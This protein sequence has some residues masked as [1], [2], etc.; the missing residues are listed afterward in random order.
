MIR[1]VIRRGGRRQMPNL[2]SLISR[3]LSIPNTY[4]QRIIER[5]PSTISMLIL[6]TRLALFPFLFAALSVVAQD[7]STI[8]KAQDLAK[9]ADKIAQNGSLHFTQ[10]E[11]MFEEAIAMAPNDAEVNMG[12][13]LCQLNGPFRSKALP[14]FQKARVSD[15]SFRHLAFLTGYALQLDAQWD[16]AMAMYQEHKKQNPYLDDPEVMYN[17]VD[18]RI[19]ECQNGVAAMAQ[20]TK[21][22]VKNMGP[23]INSPYADYGPVVAADGAALYYTSRRPMGAGAK[24]NKATKEYF[25]DIHTASKNGTE[26]SPATR[27]VEPVNTEGNDAAVGLFSDGRTMVIYRD[28]VGNGDLFESVR[29]GDSWSTPVAFGPNINTPGHETS[30]WYSFDRQWLYFVTDGLDDNVGGQ[31]I[32]RS[33]WDA[34]NKQW[35]RGENLGPTVNTIYDEDGVYVHPDGQTIYF[36]SKG[37]SSMGGY[38]IFSS[39]LENGQ[40]SKPESLGWPVNSPDDD[41]FFVMTADGSKGYFSSLRADGLGEDDIYCANFGPLDGSSAENLLVN[42]AGGATFA[43]VKP[44]TVMLK[45]KV[46]DHAKQTGVE[47]HIQFMDLANANLVADFTTDATN[48]KYLVAVPAGHDY[49]MYVKANG[50][51]THSEN[52]P[53]LEGMQH[54]DL[55]LDIAMESIKMG[56]QVTLK[57]LFFAFGSAEL[58]QRSLAELNQLEDLLNKNQNMR[59]IVAGHTDSTGSAELNQGLSEERAKAVVDYLVKRG[60]RKDRL[61]SSGFGDSQPKVPNNCSYNK[62]LNRRTEIKVL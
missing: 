37:H 5:D 19:R 38:D 13:G 15:P 7:P 30:A 48:G 62:A 41:M 56:S 20:P 31:D 39:R 12:M 4:Q 28:D 40:W 1:L 2:V 3:T 55:D 22:E 25:E 51:L 46:V 33:R 21:A 50:Y 18:R 17:D 11:A 8:K 36:S 44:T 6:N 42:A 9:K 47:A 54:L 53:V 14:Y 26:W 23:G 35:G 10:A 49:A 29:T 59:L 60:I 45:G 24:V 43:A 27:A 52:L 57:N 16:E 34:A 32:Y 61:E 58:E